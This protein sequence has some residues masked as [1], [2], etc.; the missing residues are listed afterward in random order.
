[1]GLMLTTTEHMRDLENEVESYRKGLEKMEQEHE[2]VLRQYRELRD[3]KDNE[4]DRLN[5]EIHKL[6]AQIRDLCK[7][8]KMLR[9]IIDYYERKKK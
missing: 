8:V 1:M 2:T 7:E 6:T 3:D 4:I 5:S 9:Q